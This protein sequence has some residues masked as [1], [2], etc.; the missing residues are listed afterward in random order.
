MQFLLLQLFQ[1]LH[2]ALVGECLV[3]IARLTPKILEALMCSQ[4]W[5]R[6]KYKGI[7]VVWVYKYTLFLLQ[8][9]YLFFIVDDK[10]KQPTTFWSCL[11]DIQEDLQVAIDLFFVTIN[12]N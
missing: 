12:I 11:Q 1:S 8:T 4:D 7:Y 2:L 10:E 6:N 5:T 9:N 3:S